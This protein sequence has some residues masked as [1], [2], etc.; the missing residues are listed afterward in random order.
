MIEITNKTISPDAVVNKA[1][2]NGSGCVVTYI[3]V[4]RQSSRGKNVLSVE[5]KDTR[6]DAAAKLQRVV[7]EAR[8]KWQLEGV[9]FTHRVGKL[10]VGDINLVVAVAAA[11]RTEGF[12][13]SQF[14]IY[15]FKEEL[16]TSKI[17]TYQDGT[18][19]EGN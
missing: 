7:D 3:G 16:P 6:G 13:A 12:A 19:W 18:I 2:T 1:K 14:I 8:Q 4:I 9:A 17:E 11:H 10:N 5:Y 15:R